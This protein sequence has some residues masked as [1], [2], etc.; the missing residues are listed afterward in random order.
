MNKRHKVWMSASEEGNE[1]NYTWGS[2]LSFLVLGVAGW[3]ELNN[4]YKQITKKLIHDSLLWQKIFVTI[5]FRISFCAV[6]EIVSLQ[7]LLR[8]WENYN[9]LRE[10]LHKEK[11]SAACN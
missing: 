1:T 4:E 6:K 3:K 10:K 8:V 7:K 5:I 11:I 9:L 2:E